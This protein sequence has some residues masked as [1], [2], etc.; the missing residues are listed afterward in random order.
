MFSNIPSLGLGIFAFGLLIFMQ[1]QAP[2]RFQV[3]RQL[4]AP[5]PYIEHLSFGYREVVADIMWI[6]ALQDFDY[7]DQQIAENVCRNNSWLY[8]ML[9]SITNLSPHF[10]IPYAAGSLAL[11]VIL[12][13]VEGAT[14]IFEKGIAQFPNDWPML[15]RAAYHYLYEVG[16]KNRA[17][18]LLIRA[19][20]S[21]APPF[22]F[23]LAGRLYSD[24]GKRELAESMLE[25]MIREKQD[26]EL[27][28]RLRKKIQT[29][30]H[31][32]KSEK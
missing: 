12:T 10:R 23:A 20:K 30:F 11:T 9:E 6:R 15:Y 29:T 24:T 32:D 5:P 3:Q 1:L 25:Q 7:C 31:E 17:A 22:V 4:I 16:D 27:I 2:S 14:K 21:G 28:E 18:E 26:P 8:Q 19:G 13:D